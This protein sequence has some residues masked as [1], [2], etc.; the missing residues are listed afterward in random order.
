[1]FGLAGGA[2]AELAGRVGAVIHCAAV[3]DF[4]RSDGSLEATN[5][6]GTEHVAAAA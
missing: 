6:A 3:T 4:N 5:I 2:Y 1:M